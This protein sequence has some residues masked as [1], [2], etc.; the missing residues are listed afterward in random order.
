MLKM[1]TYNTKQWAL[2]NSQFFGNDLRRLYPFL[3]LD[4]RPE[5]SQFNSVQFHP[6]KTC[7]HLKRT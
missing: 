2:D 7:M 6:I 5:F 4:L 3:S 1:H